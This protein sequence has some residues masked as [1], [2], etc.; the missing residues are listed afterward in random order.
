LI[1]LNEA[2]SAN[3]NPDNKK[4]KKQAKKERREAIAKAE[5]ALREALRAKGGK[6]SEGECRKELNALK[7]GKYPWMC[8]ATKCAVQLAIKNDFA[9][10]MKHFRGKEKFGFP[11]FKKKGQNDS[12]RMDYTALACL[13]EIGKGGQALKIPNLDCALRWQS[14]FGLM[15]KYWLLRSAARRISGTRPFPPKQI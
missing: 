10:A 15:E 12:F 13:D 7:K 8:E 9:N 3:Y 1:T 14:H 11:R 6:T 2:R 5:T 4:T